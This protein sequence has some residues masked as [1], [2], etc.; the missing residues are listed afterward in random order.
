MIRFMDDILAYFV[1]LTERLALPLKVRKE[2]I[3]ILGNIKGKTV[4][5]FGCSVG[6]LTM[7][8]AEEVGP[9]GK[10]YATDI[11]KREAKIAQK[12]FDSKG[13]KHIKV[14]H[15]LEH[16]T[17]VHPSVPDIH[18]VVS[19]GMLGYL[20]KTEKVLK[21]INERLKK[22]SKICFVDYDKFFDVIPNIEWLSDDKKIKRIF[23]DAGFRVAIIRKQGFAWKYI[24]IYGVKVRNV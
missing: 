1:L 2:V 21:E 22:G 20:Q 7:H 5:E 6:T 10:I 3:N 12:R 16:S 11:S 8:L 23:G 13:H 15:D 18:T 4:L 14:I 9:H 19:V 24:Y 17:R